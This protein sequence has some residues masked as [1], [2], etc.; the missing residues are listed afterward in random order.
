MS[1]KEVTLDERSCPNPNCKDGDG[2]DIEYGT[3]DLV[4][5]SLWKQDCKCT[6]CELEF[7][8]YYSMTYDATVYEESEVTNGKQPLRRL[9]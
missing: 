4:D 8:I 6:R 1:R 7:A 3:H 5:D 9:C 2:S